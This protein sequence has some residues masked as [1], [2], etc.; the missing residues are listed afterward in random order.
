MA[1]SL[2][3]TYVGRTRR[4]QSDIKS[5]LPEYRQ[6]RRELLL[7]MAESLIHQ[8]SESVLTTWETSYQAV[9]DQRPETS[10]L[11]TMLSFLSFDD[12]FL[13]LFGVGKQAK[14]RDRQMMQPL[15]PRCR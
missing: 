10:V 15:S 13:R 8:Y 1:V 14:A 6:R 3:G 4:L 2:A 5:Y 11:M 7:R 12:I 9:A